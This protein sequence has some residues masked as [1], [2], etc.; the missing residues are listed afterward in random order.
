MGRRL[1]SLVNR[2]AACR[3]GAQVAI[4]FRHAARQEAWIN[5]VNLLV[6][7]LSVLLMAW[8]S[9]SFDFGTCPYPSREHP[10]FVSGRLILGALV[11]FLALYVQGLVANPPDPAWVHPIVPL[12]VIALF[13]FLSDLADTAPA[14]ASPYNL[15]HMAGY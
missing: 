8:L 3:G 11:P 1:L 13:M 12:L 14:F 5:R 7:V 10:Y 4:G 6:V 15:L 2:V 9:I